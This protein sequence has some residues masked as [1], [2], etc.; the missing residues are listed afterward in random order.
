MSSEASQKEEDALN[1][2]V[3]LE[4]AKMNN[5]KRRQTEAHRVA[6]ESPLEEVKMALLSAQDDLQ[7]KSEEAA[8]LKA[9][10]DKLER[11]L[12]TIM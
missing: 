4:E 6:D 12:Q 3:Q 1:L 9:K 2:R 8:A 5:D 11:A 10:V 7:G